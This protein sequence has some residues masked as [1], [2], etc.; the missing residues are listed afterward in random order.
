MQKTVLVT[1][2]TGFIG[3]Y[4]VE[5]LLAKGGRVIASSLNEEKASL[6]PW[7]SKVT[8]LPFDIST[9]I[10]G[11]NLYEYFQHPD[12][13][14][15]L[16]WEG[17]PNYKAAFHLEENLPR[18]YA[19]IKNLVTHGLRDMTVTGTCFEYGMQEGCLSENMECFPHNPYALAKYQLLKK[20]EAL[21]DREKLNF[22]WAR[23]FYMFGKG[24]NPNSLI[25]LLDRALEKGDAEFNMSGGEQVRDF[26]PVEKVAEYIVAL[27]LQTEVE[28]QVNICSGKPITVKAFVEDYL[29]RK[30]REISLNFGFYP[31]ADY[32]PMRFWGDNRKIKKIL[33]IESP[34]TRKPNA[35]IIYEQ[36]SVPL[37]QNRVFPTPAE[38]RKTTCMDVTLAQ[39]SDTGFVFSAYF[40]ELA[41]DYDIHY[42]NEQSHSAY[43]QK[44]LE[45]VIE[46]MQDNNCLGE[47][48][49]EIGCGKA[50]FLEMLA[51]RGVDITG[52]D[53]TY[54]GNSDKVV[55]DFF[56]EK[57]SDINADFI[58]LRHTLEHISLPFD[59]IKSVAKAN[60][61]RG[62]IYIE[63]PTFDWI[64][65]NN[66]VEDIFYEHCNYF[67]LETLQMFFSKSTGGHFFNGQYIYV[68]AN[69]AD[70]KTDIGKRN[71]TPYE[72]QFQEKM[73]AYEKLINEENVAIWGAGAKGSTFLNLL[74]KNADK[75]S[76]VIDINPRKQNMYIG[77]TG[78][79]VYAPGVLAQ[80]PVN[81]IIIMNRNYAK[82]IAASVANKQIKLIEL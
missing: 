3:N 51:A 52:F 29:A 21:A 42:Q 27:A 26:L 70:V 61:Y 37:I 76:Y 9:D 47:K 4:V 62:Q 63:V 57:Y 30:N 24:Q 40:N 58:I 44:H 67:T 50:Y 49:I 11:K 77:G 46:I 41:I 13:L 59:F 6:Q 78:H 79:P 66:A 75:I 69:L 17:L 10:S 43:F 39:C 31:Y 74:D 68:I 8:Y 81:T 5:E 36:K 19:F 72:I 15:H 64:I 1:G 7:F 23:L 32:E 65:D 25:S 53:P 16:A 55:K 71:F 80:N 35:R 2:A 60:N 56:T 38:A 18:H 28:G 54:E 48:V 12:V 33:M 82:E 22:K 34:L 20:L 73:S 45:G 14:I